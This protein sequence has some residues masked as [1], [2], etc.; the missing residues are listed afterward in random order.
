MVTKVY[1]EVQCKWLLTA[2]P[3]LGLYFSLKNHWLVW[4]RSLLPSWWDKT[5]DFYIVTEEYA[6]R[7]QFKNNIYQWGKEFV[8]KAYWS[9]AKLE[10]G[11]VLIFLFLQPP[12]PCHFPPHIP[13][14]HVPSHLYPAASC[15]RKVTLMDSWSL[16]TRGSVRWLEGRGK[17]MGMFIFHPLSFHTPPFWQ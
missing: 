14:S 6:I 5:P 15:P 3:G 16:L 17:V 10:K 13:P 2:G 7:Y 11:Y 12:I 1:C 9:F 4:K 8:K